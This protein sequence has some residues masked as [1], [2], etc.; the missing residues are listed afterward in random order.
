MLELDDVT[1]IEI[2]KMNE[3]F[4]NSITSKSIRY[5][6]V[7][8]YTLASFE[9]FYGNENDSFLVL[10][11][12]YINLK[13]NNLLMFLIIFEYNNWI[14]LKTELTIRNHKYENDSFLKVVDKFKDMLLK[15]EEFVNK[16][17]YYSLIVY[18]KTFN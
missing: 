18:N 4:V 13:N 15:D 16:L 14:G 17:E 7:Y 9:I 8:G 3:Y 12:E 10:D 5:F 2:Q 6:S 1:D 11:F